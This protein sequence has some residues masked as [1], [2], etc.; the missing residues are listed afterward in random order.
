M[1]KHLL[2][3]ASAAAFS[4]ALAAP[5]QAAIYTTE[6]AFTAANPGATTVA[7]GAVTGGYQAEGTF[8]A[9]DGVDFTGT[10]LALV[11]T[12]LWGSQNSL[13]DDTYGGFIGAQFAATGA[14][15][16]YFAS[17]FN[18]GDLIDLTFLN[19]ATTLFSTGT[20]GGGVYSGF[21]FFGIDDIGSITGFRLDSAANPGGFPSLGA[22]SFADTAGA[23]PEPAT[24]ALLILGFG[25]VGGAMRRRRTSVS[26]SFV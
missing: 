2:A 17:G 3:A 15:G 12:T 26:L 14:V 5:A 23:V 24:W 8:Y 11:D 21:T 9:Q 10:N 22:I 20:A 18:G 19:G 16:F 6:A 4:I 7:F 13:L 25:V 1:T